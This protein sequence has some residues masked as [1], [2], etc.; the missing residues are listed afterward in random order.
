MLLNTLFA[1][2]KPSFAASFYGNSYIALPFKEARSSTDI[3]FKFK[4]HLS[5]ALIFLVAGTTDYCIVQ[6]E[7][8]RIKININLGSGEAEVVSPSSL[9]L[10]DLEWHD[11]SIE[12]KDANLTLMIDKSHKVQ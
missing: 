3:N 1:T 5:S 9:K 8:G 2:N 4:T 10:N 6:L 7:K 11:V 12:R